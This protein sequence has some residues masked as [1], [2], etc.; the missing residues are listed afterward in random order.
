VAGGKIDADFDRR[1]VAVSRFAER[2]IF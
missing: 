2:S 1:A